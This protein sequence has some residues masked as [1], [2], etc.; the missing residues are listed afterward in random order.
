MGKEIKGSK[1]WD[2]RGR[3]GEYYQSTS[4]IFLK[5]A[6]NLRVSTGTLKTKQNEI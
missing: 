3:W 1:G 4:S 5:M 6:L 2:K